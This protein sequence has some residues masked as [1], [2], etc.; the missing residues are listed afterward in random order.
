MTSDSTGE[1]F[2]LVRDQNGGNNSSGNGN[3]NGDGD[4]AGANLVPSTTMGVAFAAVLAGFF[5]I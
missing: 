3:G 5:M 4:S 1:I 2:V